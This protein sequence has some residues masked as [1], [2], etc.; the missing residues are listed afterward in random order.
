MRSLARVAPMGAALALLTFAASAPATR[1]G[2][3]AVCPAPESFAGVD[4]FATVSTVAGVRQPFDGSATVAACS[5]AV[6]Y[7]YYSHGQLSVLAWDPLALVP[8]ASTIALWTRHYDP[9]QLHLSHVAATFEGG[10]VVTTVAGV[11][12]RPRT[13]LVLDYRSADPFNPQRVYYDSSAP[14]GVPRAHVY[15]TDGSGYAPLA[16]P[17]PALGAA[18]CT[19][20]GDLAAERILQSVVTT[21]QSWTTPPWAIAQKFRVPL[22]GE[23]HRVRL[24]CDANAYFPYTA[25]VLDVF[26][27]AGQEAPPAVWGAPLMHTTFLNYMGLERA[28]AGHYAFDQF[29]TLEPGH[30]YW[31]VVTTV[32]EIPLYG[33]ALTGSEGPDFTAGVGPLF[34]QAANGGA[35]EPVS[36]RVLS[37]QLVGRPDPAALAVPPVRP[38]AFALAVEPNPAPGAALVRWDGARGALEVEVL[39]VRGRR[40]ARASGVAG[41]TW[42]WRGT[43]EDGSALP[44]GVYFVRG[45]DRTG[46]SSVARI[47]LVR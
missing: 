47:V 30:D 42:L 33:R 27:A 32:N 31:L 39:D 17:R 2:S 46:A 18:F 37:F 16:G 24:A 36:D 5:L 15:T 12:E 40:V 21:S 45:H 35:W 7:A 3:A 4:T 29:A 19:A 41:G 38:Q 6:A 23:L 44:A 25:G 11:A 22:R 1:T 10:L 26:D 13:S 34:T 43:R 8:D 20:D 14:A 28:W 9:S